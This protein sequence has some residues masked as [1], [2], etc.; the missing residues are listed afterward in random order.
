MARCEDCLHHN[1]CSNFEECHFRMF[2]SGDKADE[3]CK[4][5]K[6]AEDFVPKSD[7]EFWKQ[8]SEEFSKVLSGVIRRYYEVRQ[9]VAREIIAEVRQALLN[10]VLANAMGET[11]DLENFFAEL[12]K[13]YTENENG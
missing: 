8:S 1:C 2:L 11:Y 4:S 13:K 6:S 10:M 12:K 9:K 7:A 3:R 5:F